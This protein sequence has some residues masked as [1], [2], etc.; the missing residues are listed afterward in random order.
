M[1]TTLVVLFVLCAAAA[2]GQA[3]PSISNQPSVPV[4]VDHPLHAEPHAM[5]MQTP[6]AGGS[7]DGYGYEK[8]EQPLWQFGPISEP[9]PLGDIARAYRRE[10]MTGKKAEIVLEKQGS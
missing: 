1:K 5:A 4:F 8:G 2:F 7:A 10:K 6:I 3:V 9:V